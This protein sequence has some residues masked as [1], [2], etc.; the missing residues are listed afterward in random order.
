MAQIA[1]K[2]DK[3]TK[4]KVIG[5][6]FWE[7]L[8]YK[9]GLRILIWPLEVPF[10]VVR[11][12]SLLPKVTI[13][14]WQTLG[15][16]DVECYI[17]KLRVTRAWNTEFRKFWNICQKVG[18]QDQITANSELEK[19]YHVFTRTSKRGS[20]LEEEEE[21]HRKGIACK[22]MNVS[23]VRAMSGHRVCC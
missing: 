20:R 22:R 23:S 8:N 1:P 13:F 19:E 11:K 6:I 17:M 7:C 10:F 4:I 16:K 15:Y 18:F 14:L 5:A 2:S 9:S 3:F 12:W 21:E